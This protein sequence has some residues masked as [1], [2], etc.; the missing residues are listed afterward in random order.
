MEIAESKA[1]F[2]T[3]GLNANTE[4]SKAIRDQAAVKPSNLDGEM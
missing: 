1:T 3:A 2:F 4:F